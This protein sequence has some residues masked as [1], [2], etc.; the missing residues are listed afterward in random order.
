MNLSKVSYFLITLIAVVFILI[1]GK[2]LLIP[3]V[4]AMLLWFCVN[5]TKGV[6]NKWTWAKNKLPSWF[7]SLL[8]SF[9]LLFIISL[10]SKVISSSIAKL[11]VSYNTY[12]ANAG[13][14]L[15]S[16]N[17]KFNIDIVSFIKGY[18]GEIEFGSILSLL[19]NSISDLLS[20]SFMVVLYALFIFIE[21]AYFSKKMERIIQD[22]TSYEKTS[23][24]IQNINHSIANYL[25][26][27]TLVSAITGILSYIILAFIGID[28]PIFWAFLIFIL[29]FIPTIGSLI[30]TLF[31]AI[32]C[33][34]QFGDF[35]SG[36]LVLGLVG[37]VQLLVGNIIEP[38]FMGNSMNISPLVAIISL[39]F[40]GAIWGI[41]G[42]VISV[43][44]TVV[45]I[46]VFSQFEHT[47]SLAIALSEKGEITGASK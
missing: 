1:I 45:L 43:P 35:T 10:I 22:K 23:L 7:K 44:I 19:F 5:Q 28:S 42:M 39:S 2:G 9:F 31:P 38:K 29:N 25:G 8:A 18:S 26:L 34:L 11:S 30:G 15:A 47:K 21:E 24:I 17:T 37:G 14:L 27:K 33:I 6:L 46:I 16:V 41:T 3:F 40:W 13:D 4:F 32:F 36:F 12:K 20:N